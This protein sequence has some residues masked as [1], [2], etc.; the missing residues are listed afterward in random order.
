MPKISCSSY[1]TPSTQIFCFTGV[2]PHPPSSLRLSV[3][4]VVCDCVHV[5]S[6]V[7]AG[8][9]SAT[10]F[11]LVPGG[12]SPGTP[13]THSSRTITGNA[14]GVADVKRSSGTEVRSSTPA[15]LSNFWP[16]PRGCW[17]RAGGGRSPCGVRRH[18]SFGFSD[19]TRKTEH[20]HSTLASNVNVTLS[21]PGPTGV[22]ARVFF[23]RLTWLRMVVV[24]VVCSP[25]GCGAGAGCCCC[26]WAP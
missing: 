19:A 4:Y 8:C 23:L 10:S 9:G 17:V 26:C 16:R 6:L 2:I 11:N 12:E 24:R 21:F 1:E 15:S 5:S 20:E 22:T 14:L 7:P 18:P 25:V 13:V 3:A